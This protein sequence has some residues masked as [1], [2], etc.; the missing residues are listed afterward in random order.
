MRGSDRTP[1]LCPPSDVAEPLGDDAAVSLARRL[2]AVADPVRVKIL[3]RLASAGI[4]GVCVCDLTEPLGITQPSVSY[5]LRI[6]RQ[7]GLVVRRQERNF[8]YYSVRRSALDELAALLA[9]AEPAG[10]P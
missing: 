4:D 10:A 6:L 1:R 2:K 3:H 7:A 8:A 9:P 5:H